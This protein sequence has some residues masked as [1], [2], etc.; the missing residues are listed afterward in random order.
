[1]KTISVKEVALALGVTPRAVIYKLQ[2]GDLKGTR[3][4]NQYGVQ[5]WRIYPNKQIVEGLQKN[6]PSV[7]EPINFNPEEAIDVTIEAEKVEEEESGQAQDLATSMPVQFR[8]LVEECVRPLVEELKKQTTL[9]VAKESLIQDQSR[10]L[11]LLP[12]LEKRAEEDRLA[13]QQRTFEIEALKKQISAL[14]EEKIQLQI[15]AAEEAV[16]PAHEL[17]QLKS[18]VEEL[19]RPWWKK[20]LSKTVQTDRIAS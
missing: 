13:A 20:L 19:K 3:T 7:A 1:V 8:T 10:Q 5:E 15:K 17:Q 16:W 6:A 12:D 18:E 4:P 11:R 9:L 14:E 2:N